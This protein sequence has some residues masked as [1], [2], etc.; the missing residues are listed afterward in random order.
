MELDELLSEWG[1]VE[2]VEE[3]AAHRSE[4]EQA[5][6]LGDEERCLD[7]LGF[8][9]GTRREALQ[10]VKRLGAGCHVSEVFCPPRFTA[11]AHRYGLTPGLAFDLRSGWDLDDPQAQK[12]VWE[13]LRTERPLLVVGSPE[14]KAFSA[15][16]NLNPDSP[17]YRATLEAGRRHLEFVSRVYE[18]QSEQGRLFLHEHPLAATSWRE[19]CIQRV[20]GLPRAQ[21]AKCD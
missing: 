4:L 17:K 9:S 6:W 11:M 1:I 20:A 7:K 18:Y 14:C 15:L 13:H 12:A 21:V 19:P 3:R 16:H 10:L 5:G 8:D 2:M